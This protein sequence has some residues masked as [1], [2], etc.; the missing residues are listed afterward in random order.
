MTE[1][2]EVVTGPQP[3][4]GARDDKEETWTA[5]EDREVVTGPQP[6]GGVRDDKEETS[7]GPPIIVEEWSY[8]PKNSLEERR[9]KRHSYKSPTNAT[10]SLPSSESSVNG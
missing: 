1:D 5:A 6:V 7:K 2:R 4:G 8:K 10:S 3:V 9:K